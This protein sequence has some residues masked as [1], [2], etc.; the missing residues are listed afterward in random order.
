MAIDDIKNISRDELERD[1]QILSDFL[2]RQEMNITFGGITNEAM[3]ADIRTTRKAI[4]Q[5]HND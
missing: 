2:A 4:Q 5:P 1:A 3:I